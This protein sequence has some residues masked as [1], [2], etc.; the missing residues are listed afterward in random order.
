MSNTERLSSKIKQR[1]FKLNAL[2]E[3]TE[4]INANSSEEDLI[5]QFQ[6]TVQTHLG[7]EKLALFVKRDD[8]ECLLQY[9]DINIAEFAIPNDEFFLSNKDIALSE[10]S[11]HES[12]DVVIPVLHNNRPLALALA[13]DN[14]ENARGM[15]ATVKHMRFLQTLTSV[16]SVA[17][18]NKRLLTN[19]V[20]Q[21]RLKKELE[22]A[23]EMQQL[24]LP[25]QFPDNPFW[26]VQGI[27]R[28]HQQVGGDYYDVFQIAEH[29]WVFC[30]GD[31]S[32][33]G[34]PAAFL[35]SNFQA[36]VRN[37]FEEKRPDLIQLAHKL[38]KRVWD[39][40]QGEK[41]ITF[42]LGIYNSK[43]QE[44][45]YVNCGHNAPVFKSNETI[46]HLK[47]AAI[48]LGMLPELPKVSV[49]LIQINSGDIL[50]GYTDGLVEVNNTAGDYFEIEGIENNLSGTHAKDVCINVER[51][52][53][54][55]RGE[56]LYNDDVAILAM[57]W[58]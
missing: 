44:I 38:N 43:N 13:G 45:E 7:I 48:G 34:M 21:E 16:L 5:F 18:E 2:L 6:N 14:E 30:L 28:A 47:A 19:L 37:A 56:C 20:Q 17:L 33:K 49:G 23:A 27:Y 3:L 1:D 57:L 40:V 11:T 9:G 8:W 35:M 25:S 15:S 39:A 51:A 36:Y 50:L 24:L 22:L 58:K 12:F 54:D 52:A 53:N 31:V 41:F 26:C 46:T 4:A 55:F 42:F 10:D 32:G 29:E